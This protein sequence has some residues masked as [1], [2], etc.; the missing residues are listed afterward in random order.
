[1]EDEMP[2]ATTLPTHLEKE[3]REEDEEEEEAV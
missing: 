1:M 3:E 2:N